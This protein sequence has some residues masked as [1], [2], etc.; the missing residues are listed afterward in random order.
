MISV[1][2][3]VISA[4]DGLAQVEASAQSGCGGCTSRSNCGVS[5]LGKYISAGRKTVA[6]QCGAKVQA[7][8][9]LQ[10][11]LSEADLLKAGLLAYVIPS[12]LAVAG[13]GVATA[14]DWGDSG[15]AL[16][17]GIGMVAGLLLG[18]ISGWLPRIVVEK[19]L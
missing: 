16:G 10:L 9:E 17:A 15:A 18:R 11:Q 14:L 12:V 5:G 4:T 7:G 13:A 6:V 2:V 3:R 19:K 8:D 1:P